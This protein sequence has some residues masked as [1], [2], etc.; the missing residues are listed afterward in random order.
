MDSQP[1]FPQSFRCYKPSNHKV[2][3]TV[4]I[5]PDNT[6]LVVKGRRSG[7]WSFPKGHKLRSET[8]INCALRETLEETG[9]NLQNREHRCYQKMSAGEYYF[10]DVEEELETRV[11]DSTE[12]VEAAWL[13]P[14][15]LENLECNVDVNY[16]LSR[17]NRRS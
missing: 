17:R 11:N 2:Y 13:S 12:V 14:T 8:Y 7:K 9:V 15:E 16:W 1:V 6:I 10:F 4:C 5:T 3:G